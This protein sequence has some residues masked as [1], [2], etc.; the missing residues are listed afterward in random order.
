M[1]FRLEGIITPAITPFKADEGVDLKRLREHLDF[2]IE[3]GISGIFSLGTAGE[4][5]L[6]SRE[7]RDE[8]LKVTVDQVNGKVPV[9]AGVS[10]PG[11]RNVISNARR[12]SEIG[13]DAV[14][15]T[16]PYFYR[17]NEEGIYQHFRTIAENVDIPIVVYNIPSATGHLIDAKT[18]EKLCEI[19][20]I[21]AMK[22]T[23]SDF[24]SFLSLSLALKNRV[25]MFIG[26]D[27]LIYSGLDMGAAGAVVGSSNAIP[28]QTVEIYRL[29]R[30]G[31]HAEAKFAQISIMPFV[32]VMF[33]G[34]FP[35]ALK[36]ALNELGMAVGEVRK[37]L[38]PLNENER[39]EI[40]KALE[41][42]DRI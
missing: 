5:A 25:S 38:M 27:A 19:D 11:T 29:Y 8:V 39:K 15:V 23:A 16:P 41:D 21:V 24:S 2:L 3:N 31:E 35:S 32:D 18:A 6:L 10:D 36:A 14:V 17:T 33:T 4:F 30:S 42:L 28:E 34:T 40:R 7:E 12:A 22:Y 1:L 13:A 37:P 26:D 9:L 20:S